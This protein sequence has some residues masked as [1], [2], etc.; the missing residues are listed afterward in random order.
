MG[1]NR[2][3]Q[4]R[5]AAWGRLG[6]SVM[7]S[8]S[9][10]LGGGG[11]GPSFPPPWQLSAE[12]SDAGGQLDLDGKLR[13][14]AIASE[15]P[16][17]RPGQSV[18]V[19]SLIV[20]H[21]RFGEVTLDGDRSVGTLRPR[22]LSVLYRLC[23]LPEAM[24][25]PL[26]CGLFPQTAQYTELPTRSDFSTETQIPNQLG[27]PSVQ[28][29]TLIAADH[30]YPGGAQACAV[31]AADNGG[32]S[33]S[34]NHCVIAVKRIKVSTTTAP[35]HNPVLTK[36]LLGETEGTLVDAESGVATY[37]K[38]SAELREEDRPK[39][40]VVIERATDSEEQ[41]PDPLDPGRQRA[42]LLSVSLFVTA[43]TLE[44]GRGSFLDLT[45]TSDCPQ[46]LRSTLSWQ[47]PAALAGTEAVDDRTHFVVVLRDDRGGTSFRAA[48]AE[49]R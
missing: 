28:L 36:I 30:S 34:P 42:E 23:T 20:V 6:G 27:S 29:V 14:L 15:P 7:I 43:G 12:P 21:P 9:V 47:P 18:K 10:L 2:Q 16:E 45:C 44:S 25:S 33:P 49:A 39:W 11:C 32:L 8:A 41:E 37:P 38:L 35:N 3:F 24:T 22:G 26:P 31:A 1:G 13:V 40:Q 17:V 5:R 19:S 4:R 48:V 46:L